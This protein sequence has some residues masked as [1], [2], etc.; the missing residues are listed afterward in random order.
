MPADLT[1]GAGDATP[2]TVT[3]ARV[4]GFRWTPARG[5]AAAAAVSAAAWAGIAYLVIRM[6]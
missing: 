2:L 6:L 5:L 1:L 3:P 4:R